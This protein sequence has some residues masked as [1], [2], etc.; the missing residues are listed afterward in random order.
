[1]IFFVTIQYVFKD[2]KRL[3]ITLQIFIVQKQDWS[4]NL[5]VAVTTQRSKQEKM[6]NEPMI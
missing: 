1:M 4:S 5:M 3:E 2:K 6:N